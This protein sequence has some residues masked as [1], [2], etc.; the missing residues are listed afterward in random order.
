M[1]EIISDRKILRISPFGRDNTP[2]I[3]EYD[4]IHTYVE[5]ELPELKTQYQASFNVGVNRHG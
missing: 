3:P 4:W 1:I 5:Y 2:D